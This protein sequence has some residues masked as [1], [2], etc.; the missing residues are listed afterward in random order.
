MKAKTKITLNYWYIAWKIN[1]MNRIGRKMD[2]LEK[3]DDKY[4]TQWRNDFIVKLF[5]K[6]EKLSMIEMEV[7]GWDNLPK[8]PAVLAA[9]HASLWDP[10]AIVLALKNPKPGKDY[11]NHK[12]AFLGKDDLKTHKRAKGLSRMM[13]VF[14]LD[15]ENARKSL[16]TLNE[17]GEYAKEEKTFAVI[18]PEGKRSLD[19]TIQEFKSG[20]F[21]LAKKNFMPIVPVTIIN[22]FAS[23]N[24]DRDKVLKIKV[25]FGKAIKPMSIISYD[26]K[27]LAKLVQKEVEKNWTKPE[28]S[29]SV[30]GAKLG[31]S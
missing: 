12:S 13:N 14:F 3:D 9:N 6:V 29:R 4:P 25:I 15:R 18:F 28:G 5:T 19:G 2:K 1:R 16:N 27:S 7:E 21:R 30:K 20:A 26:T 10:A 24:L 23:S 17:F 22:S 31:N 8:A 11:L